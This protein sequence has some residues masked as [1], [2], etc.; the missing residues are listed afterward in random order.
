MNVNFLGEIQTDKYH[1]EVYECGYCHFAIGL[2]ATYLE[3]ALD[4]YETLVVVCPSCEIDLQ[5]P[6]AIEISR[7]RMKEGHTHANLSSP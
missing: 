7:I 4:E 6:N 1:L 2:D 3:Q 5:F